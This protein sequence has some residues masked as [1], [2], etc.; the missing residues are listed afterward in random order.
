[1]RKLALFALGFL[2]TGT[3]AK[4]ETCYLRLDGKEI[5]YHLPCVVERDYNKLTIEQG[6]YITI[7]IDRGVLKSNVANKLTLVLT[8]R[9][10]EI[11]P[12]PSRWETQGFRSSN[13]QCF[14]NA[15]VTV[16]VSP[17]GEVSPSRAV[18]RALSAAQ[19]SASTSAGCPGHRCGSRDPTRDGIARQPERTVRRM[20]D[21]ARS[22][23]PASK[24]PR[25][26]AAEPAAPRGPPAPTP[27]ARG[28]PQHPR[29]PCPSPADE[30]RRNSGSRSPASASAPDPR[31]Q[32]CRE[33]QGPRPHAR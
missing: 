8:G 19:T 7:E 28:L 26:A 5:F 25:P 22:T 30:G 27:A 11:S 16:C 14:E 24:N 23:S 17:Q 1:M 10:G 4:A 13:L 33:R 12:P 9:P 3:A 21:H 31:S 29:R 15:R 6:N 20:S 18:A 2:L 32:Q